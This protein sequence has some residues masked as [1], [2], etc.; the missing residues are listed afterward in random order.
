[1]FTAYSKSALSLNFGK[2]T[3]LFKPNKSYIYQLIASQNKQTITCNNLM[4]DG[5]HFIQLLSSTNRKP[6]EK[7]CTNDCDT[8]RSNLGHHHHRRHATWD[9]IEWDGM[10]WVCSPKPYPSETFFAQCHVYEHYCG[11]RR[12]NNNIYVWLHR[13]EIQRKAI[14]IDTEIH[15]SLANARTFKQANRGADGRSLVCP[16]V[17][18]FSEMEHVLDFDKLDWGAGNFI[19]LA[20]QTP[21]EG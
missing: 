7:F 20:V 8:S 13:P 4:G 21:F 6:I 9:G 14:E 11:R 12:N 1:M 5:T 3:Y 19:Q 2:Q 10:R 16:S 15:G 17:R 18:S